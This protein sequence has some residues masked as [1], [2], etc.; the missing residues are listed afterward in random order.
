MRGAELL[1]ARLHPEP[2]DLLQEP[3][4]GRF[5]IGLS[6]LW[7]VAKSVRTTLNHG[8]R[9]FV[10]ICWY[11]QLTTMFLVL[12]STGNLSLLDL[13]LLVSG[14]NK[15]KVG[16]TLAYILF[17]YSAFPSGSQTTCFGVTFPTLL[18]CAFFVGTPFLV[19]LKR[20]P[21]GV[22]L[23]TCLEGPNPI[24]R[25]A[26]LT[27]KPMPEMTQA[28][29][30]LSVAFGLSAFSISGASKSP[31]GAAGG[32]ESCPPNQHSS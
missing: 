8:K 1:A 5:Y 14:L 26:R 21:K 30:L 6:I 27:R 24:L 23:F 11:L 2:S 9:A 12:G 13:F 28:F 20:K 16:P 19:G 15:W 31:A 4:A 22:F 29:L 25:Q 32:L 18:G 7:M 10:G 3:W 17:D